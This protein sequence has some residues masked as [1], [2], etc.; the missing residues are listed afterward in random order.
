MPEEDVA[1]LFCGA[2]GLGSGF[3]PFF[4]VT[5]AIDIM[6]EAVATYQE[7][8]PE[9]DVKRQDV[10][11][12][13]GCYHDFEGITGIIG[14]PPC[15]AFSRMNLKKK[16]GDPRIMLTREYMR[17]VEEIRP[18]FF[19]MENVPYTPKE[20]KKKVIKAGEDAGYEVTSL[21]LNAAD[22]GSAQ[23]RHRWVVIGVR[24]RKWS[25]PPV[26]SPKTV[27]TALAGIL[28][29]WGMMTS[30]PETLEKLTHA[31]H[32]VWTPLSGGTFKNLIKLQWDHPAPAVV[33]LKKVYMVHPGENRNIS[34]A[35]A[36]AL[37]G[38]PQGYVW[39]GTEI[40]IAQMIANAMPVELANSIAQTLIRGET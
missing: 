8:H 24:D 9:T 17:L 40:A 32:D 26:Q 2:G 33:N 37:Q 4:N 14:G 6:P 21:F 16:E 29:N 20:Q 30:S 38:F 10:R 1:D 12:M 39:K 34:L 25:I 5:H 31:L 15:Q 27:R 36:A 18:R 28:N 22:Y 13:T 35:E 7:N 11:N 19:V 23:K 3:A